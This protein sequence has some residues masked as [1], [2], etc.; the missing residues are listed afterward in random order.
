MIDVAIIGVRIKQARKK[1]GFTQKELARKV[2][3]AEVTIKKYENARQKPSIG[4]LRL[5]AY[6]LHVTLAYL[7]GYENE[8]GEADIVIGELIIKELGYKPAAAQ[9][10]AEQIAA[11]G[12]TNHAFGTLAFRERLFQILNEADHTD[13]EATEVDEQ[14]LQAICSGERPF[15]FDEA[16]EIADA[17]G[18]SLDYL[19][20]FVDRNDGDVFR[21]K[22]LQHFKLF[23]RLTSEQQEIIDALIMQMLTK[24]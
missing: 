18:E 24:E 17:I 22:Y 23:D 8:K 14:A 3:L 10:L 19:A 6:T 12:Q 5:L 16:C 9:A 21:T 15:S 4:Q 13:I 7:L 1:A 2:G 20:G 11:E